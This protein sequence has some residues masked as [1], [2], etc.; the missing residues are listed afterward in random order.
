M[1][2]HK[3]FLDE[4]VNI[5]KMFRGADHL[6]FVTYPVVKD[7]KLLLRALEELYNAVVL[8]ISLILRC[9]YL[10]KRVDLSKDIKK[11]FKTFLEKCSG[12]YGLNENDVDILENL[13]LLLTHLIYVNYIFF[14]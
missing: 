13:F 7:N 8:N 14:K 12:K 10:Y 5:E 6:I 9:E 2:I 11:N 3:D 4:L 1:D